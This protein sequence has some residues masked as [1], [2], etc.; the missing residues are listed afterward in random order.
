MAIIAV[1]VSAALRLLVFEFLGPEHSFPTF[2]PAVVLSTIYGG[3]GAG[4]IATALSAVL[5]TLFIAPFGQFGIAHQRDLI[6]WLL[7]IVMELA[8][9]L[10]CEA[11][12][13][14]RQNE[15]RVLEQLERTSRIKDEFLA[16]LSHELR[17]PLSAIIGWTQ[18][19]RT[20]GA[21]PDDLAEGLAAIERNAHAQSRIVSDLLDM[22]RI[23]SGKMRLVPR[24][25]DVV[26]VVDAGLQTVKL[27]AAAKQ[28]ALV[29]EVEPA[30]TAMVRGDPDR[31]QQVVWN[32][33]T[34]AIKFTPPGGTVTVRAGCDAAL[35]HVSIAVR[36]SGCG[37]APAFLPHVFEKFRQERT[38]PG[39]RQPGLGLGLAIVR[40]LVE[41]HGGT[42]AAS[43]GGENAGA[44][45]TVTLPACSPEAPPPDPAKPGNQAL[46]PAGM[47]ID[48]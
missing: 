18:L 4:L 25:C 15:R 28:I 11:F 7:F 43:S 37:I 46:V 32:L 19:L 14:A 45:F 44:V 8:L 13:L 6:G 9:V 22:S 24:P 27:A 41:L 47:R 10:I 23:I 29:R 33:L 16:S 17:T 38:A 40:Q 20:E 2:Y 39:T 48:D 5:A 42:V 26:D 21:T 3:L 36:D 31:L 35:G 34:N 1:I 30:G 12:R